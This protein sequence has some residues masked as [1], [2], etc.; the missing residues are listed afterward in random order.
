MGTASSAL[1]VAASSPPQG[2]EVISCVHC[3]LPVPASRRAT[4]HQP[5]Y[6]CFGCRFASELA[7]RATTDTETDGA[8][9]P[10]TLLLRLGL[11]ILLSMNIM[12]FKGLFYSPLVYQSGEPDALRHDA[13]QQLAAYF[14]M[15]LT[16]GV[17]VTLGM[18]LLNDVLAGFATP[19]LDGQRRTW[20]AWLGALPRRVDANLLICIGVGAAFTLSVIHTVRGH[21]TLYFDTAALILTLVTLGHY[22]DSTARRRAT[23]AARDLLTAMPTRTWVQRGDALVE[24]D[25]DA[26]Q[27]G[28]HVRVRP[29]ETIPVDGRVIE[30]SGYINESSLTGESNPRAVAA[31]DHVMAG[32]MSLDGQLWIEATQVGNDR[33]LAQTQKLLETARLHQLPLQRLADRISAVF[34]PGVVLLAISVFAFNAWIGDPTSGLFNALSVLLISCP[35]ALGLAA[36]LATWSTLHRAARAGILIDSAIT[37]ERAA[38]IRHVFFDKTGTLTEPTLNL[39][40]VHTSQ[41]VSRDEALRIAGAIE[42]SSVH[43]IAVALTTHA[44]QATDVPLPVAEDARA[45][46]GLGVQAVVEGR[47]YWLGSARLVQQRQLI[48]IETAN[49]AGMCVY[50]MDETRV[51]ACFTLTEKLR[52]D[53]KRAV[54]SLREMGIDATI[55]TGD[56]TETAERVGRALGIGV[57][58]SLLPADKLEHLLTA[59]NDVPGRV[60][61]VG[62]GIN[63]GPVLAA[64]DVGFAMRSSTSLAQQAGNV[65]LLADRLDRVPFTI[66]MARHGMRRVKLN[67]LWA[68]GYNTIGLALAAMGYLNPIFAASAMF[69]SSLL[70]VTTS[71]KA[72]AV[73]QWQEGA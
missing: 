42:S 40:A 71:R 5:S 35:C 58:A 69:V 17:I 12:A 61:M 63:D 57:K 49:D 2:G 39:H 13:L 7:Q 25:A 26:V 9:P 31:G 41:D 64:A 27:V 16:T 10:N 56:R 48:P 8:Q 67:L 11:G 24:V 66:A 60:A 43:P 1:A 46:P 47:T 28:D 59:R 19:T 15:L 4:G 33:T 65:R 53:A 6:C 36:P 73:P 22:L 50:L 21:G 37:L 29:G 68:F 3:G 55:L 14:M 20:R 23:A 34:V 62:D 51:L 70:I 52:D 44:Q 32:C 72:G 45:L 30:G 38:A 54:R 18:P